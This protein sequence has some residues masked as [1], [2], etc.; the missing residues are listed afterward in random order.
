MSSIESTNDYAAVPL[1]VDNLIFDIMIPTAGREVA[2]VSIFSSGQN[3][4]VNDVPV[5]WKDS[6]RDIERH[7]ERLL[8]QEIRRLHQHLLRENSHRWLIGL[9]SG[10]SCRIRVLA[11]YATNQI[12]QHRKQLLSKR[13]DLTQR[14]WKLSGVSSGYEQFTFPAVAASIKPSRSYRRC[15]S[16]RMTSGPY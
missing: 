15:W 3:F 5:D 12:N 9:L 1:D 6:H 14:I 10:L 7:T 11:Q 16:S 2:D 13:S 8:H 4:L